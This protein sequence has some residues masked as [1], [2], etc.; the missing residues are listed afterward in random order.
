MSSKILRVGNGGSQKMMLTVSVLMVSFIITASNATPKK[1]C[2]SA[3]PNLHHIG[4]T[5]AFFGWCTDALVHGKQEC[6]D[7]DHLRSLVALCLVRE[8]PTSG[9]RNYCNRSSG[10]WCILHYF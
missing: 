2:R 9:K 5:E 6:H 8:N 7:T 3:Q 1:Q 10:K 4:M